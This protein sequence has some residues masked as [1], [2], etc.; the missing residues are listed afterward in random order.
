[1]RVLVTG[2]AGFVGS[3]LTERLRRLGHLVIAVDRNQRRGSSGMRA[4]LLAI[5]PDQLPPFDVC[6]HLASDVGGFLH[7]VPDAVGVLAGKIGG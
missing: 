4:D 6:F 2:S 1:M 5:E 7:N 3:A